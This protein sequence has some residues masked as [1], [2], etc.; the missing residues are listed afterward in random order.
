MKFFLLLISVLFSPYAYAV[1]EEP[2]IAGNFILPYTQQPGA[3]YG[4]G[5]N[6]LAKNELQVSILGDN[7]VGVGNHFV[8]VYPILIY[9]ITDNLS[10]LLTMPVASSYKE[11]GNHSSGVEDTFLQFEY[12]FFNKSTSTYSDSATVVVNM[13]YP[14]GSAQKQPQTGFGSSTYFLGFTWDRTYVDWFLFTGY[15]AV[16]TTQRDGIKLGNEYLYQY[17]FGRNITNIN[18]K[19]ILAWM[20]E[21]DGQYTEKSKS[22]GMTDPDTGG[23]FIYVTPSLW[24]SSKNLIFQLGA[25]WPIT[26]NLL[27]NQSSN[28]YLLIGNI[29]WSM[30]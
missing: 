16:F 29:T 14:T 30:Y 20:V 15:G 25:G 11:G 27:G 26:Q 12:N 19:W 8:D 5:Q 7:F 2:P 17:G 18:N 6:I 28:K 9:G 3:L 21:V 24:L 23:N 1:D 13:S 22:N 10:V 4:F